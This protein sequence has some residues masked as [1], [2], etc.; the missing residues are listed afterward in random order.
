MPI[1]E[2]SVPPF[3][4]LMSNESLQKTNI[5]SLGLAAGSLPVITMPTGE[6]IPTGTMG[7]L[8][9]NIK[10]YDG[11][12]ETKRAELEPKIQQA[13]PALY[14]VGLFDLFSPEEWASAHSPGR[15]LVGKLARDYT[16]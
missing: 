2:K 1:L 5:Q 9:F 6:K 12:D 16:K 7:A 4:Y 14:E 3:P 15:S 13:I 8:L 10:A 11:G